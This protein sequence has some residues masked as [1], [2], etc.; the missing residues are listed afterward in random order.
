MPLCEIIGVTPVGKN[1]NVAYAFMRDESEGTYQWVLTKLRSMLE[2]IASPNVIVTDR[3]LGLLNAL[4]VVFPDCY[5]LLCLFHI[6][7]NVESNVIKLMG[8]KKRYALSFWGARFILFFCF[9]IGMVTNAWM[10]TS[11]VPFHVPFILC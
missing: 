5:H 11:T 7:R 3:E 6:N 4:E 1:F 8:R 10:G 9:D 2:G